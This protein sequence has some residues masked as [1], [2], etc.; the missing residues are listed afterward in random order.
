MNSDF[1]RSDRNRENTRRTLA[2]NAA[3]AS[4]FSAITGLIVVVALDL[5][6]FVPLLYGKSS[7][8][9]IRDFLSYQVDGQSGQLMTGALLL[10][11][12]SSWSYAL[13]Q[14]FTPGQS[15]NRI[16]LWATILFGFGLFVGACFPAMPN[17]KHSGDMAFRMSSWL[18]DVGIGGGFIPAII[19]AMVDQYKVVLRR[20]PGYL[21]TKMSFW[22]IVVGAVSTGCAVIACKGVEGLTQRIFVLGVVLW[23]VTE[24]HQVFWRNAEE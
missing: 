22:M 23:L 10:L 14:F 16:T 2:Q 18:H 5:T 4:L 6:S 21:L 1:S 8:N 7:Y 11:A 15:Y 12:T 17:A 13:A 24:A 3:F 20:T 19:A 9:P